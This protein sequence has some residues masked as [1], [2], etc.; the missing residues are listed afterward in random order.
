MDRRFH[1][2]AEHAALF[3]PCFIPCC[4]ER[5]LEGCGAFL[6]KKSRVSQ[7]SH[8]FSIDSILSNPLRREPYE[9]QYRRPNWFT[10][11]ETYHTANCFPASE[12][13]A[14]QFSPA[15]RHTVPYPQLD[16]VANLELHTTPIGIVHF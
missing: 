12:C 3:D 1:P 5:C 11:G 13:A 10:R 14:V 4:S 15:I 7:A 9:V 2:S 6:S 8:Q 16:A